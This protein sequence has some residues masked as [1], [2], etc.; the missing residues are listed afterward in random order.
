MRPG[1]FSLLLMLRLKIGLKKPK[2]VVHL[3]GCHPFDGGTHIKEVYGVSA[4]VGRLLYLEK[5]LLGKCE[6][7]ALLVVAS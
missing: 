1:Y 5:V 3:C 6:P 7:F 2:I 4:R